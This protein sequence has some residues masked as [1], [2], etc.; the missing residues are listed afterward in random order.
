M[1]TYSSSTLP[2]ENTLPP[3]TTTTTTSTRP[4]SYQVPVSTTIT[5]QSPVNI[6]PPDLPPVFA[7]SV[8]APTTYTSPDNTSEIIDDVIDDLPQSIKSGENLLKA[9]TPECTKI[10]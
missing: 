10:E 5:P 6:T 1:A 2:P 9:I 8:S 4:P 7:P 3:T